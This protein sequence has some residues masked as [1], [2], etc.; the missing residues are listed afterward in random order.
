MVRRIE[1]DVTADG[2]VL[3][4]ADLSDTRNFTSEIDGVSLRVRQ[5][6]TVTPWFRVTLD[7]H[8][9][10]RLVAHHAKS[11]LIERYTTGANE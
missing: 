3:L 9:Y 4:I 5:L 1:L 7:K 6:N 2:L 10:G 8:Q 11:Q